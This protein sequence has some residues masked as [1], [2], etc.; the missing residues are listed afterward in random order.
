MT[1]ILTTQIKCAAAAV[2]VLLFVS[3]FSRAARADAASWMYVGGGAA[4]VES[5]AS[6]ASTRSLMQLD[7]GFGSNPNGTLVF[8]G[9]VRT[10]THFGGGTDLALAQ[11]TATGGFCRGDWGLALDVGGVQRWWGEDSTGLIGTLTAG[12]PW[13]LQL[14]LLASTGTNGGQMFGVSFGLDWARAT[15]HRTTGTRW[16]PNRVLP[17]SAER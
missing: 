1:T 10:L 13:G 11:R 5:D 14:S 9:I 3:S 7:A 2:A 15:A 8:G 17:V 12:A 6:A 16:W 4:S